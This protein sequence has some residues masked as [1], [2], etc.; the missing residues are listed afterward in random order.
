MKSANPSPGH[1]AVEVPLPAAARAGQDERVPRRDARAEG[2]LV[3]PAHHREIVADLIGIGVGHPETG[4][5]PEAE[6]SSHDDDHAVR[7]VAVRV[8]AQVVRPKRGLVVAIRA[9]A[10]V[11]DAKR[12]DHVGAEHR[13]IAKRHRLRHVVDADVGLVLR[14]EMV[15]WN[16]DALP[17]NRRDVPAEDRVVGVPLVVD[18]RHELSL[19]ALASG[20]AEREPQF[21]AGIIGHRQR[22]RQGSTP[23]G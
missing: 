8:D 5:G 16:G 20:T 21:A 10:V 19:V 4:V 2:Q 7:L 15:V 22:L 18:L 13:G 12:V 3:V 6:P 17:V 9:R 23:R 11:G 14:R 1:L